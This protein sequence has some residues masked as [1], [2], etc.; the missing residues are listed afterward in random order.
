[1]SIWCQI[2]Y[3]WCGLV[4]NIILLIFKIK[5]FKD[6]EYYSVLCFLD[7]NVEGSP[8]T[9]KDVWALLLQQGENRGHLNTQTLYQSTPR[10][11]A[12]LSPWKTGTLTLT[13][14]LDNLDNLDLDN[15]ETLAR[16]LT[17]R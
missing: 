1:M 4:Y 2:I 14:N 16:I 6:L 9:N 17:I 8:S 13:N 3:N 10:A 7:P 12:K 15:L 5:V 11:T